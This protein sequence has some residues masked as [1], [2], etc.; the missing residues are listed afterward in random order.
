VNGLYP[1]SVAQQIEAV[2]LAEV[3]VVENMNRLRRRPSEIEEIARRLR[4]A[5]A[6][7]RMLEDEAAR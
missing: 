2:Q 5:A 6:T 1:P 4:A 7:L 3:H